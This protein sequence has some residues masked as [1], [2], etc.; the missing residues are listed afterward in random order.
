MS[1]TNKTPSPLHDFELHKFISVHF[2]GVVISSTENPEAPSIQGQGVIVF[3]KQQKEG[4]CPT[5]QAVGLAQTSP[6]DGAAFAVFNDD[7]TLSKD[8]DGETK[9]EVYDEKHEIF[10]WLLTIV[11]DFHLKWDE[12]LFIA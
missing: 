12:I 6:T 11:T 4:K 3:F 5:R 10:F 7:V 9:A 1:S 8:S 2:Q